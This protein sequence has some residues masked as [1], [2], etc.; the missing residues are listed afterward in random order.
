MAND[1]RKTISFAEGQ[2]DKIHRI[3][4]EEGRNFSNMVQRIVTEWFEV[5]HQQN[6]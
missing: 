3:A 5:L 1:N 2:I 4:K 6:E